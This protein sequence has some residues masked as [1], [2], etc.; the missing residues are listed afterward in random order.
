MVLV[1]AIDGMV[2][3]QFHYNQVLVRSKLQGQLHAGIACSW[4]LAHSAYS[5][6]F[7]DSTSLAEATMDVVGEARP[8]QQV[9]AGV[10]NLKY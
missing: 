9:V 5:T 8:V 7:L 6:Y 3:P 4:S 1:F 10:F 2:L